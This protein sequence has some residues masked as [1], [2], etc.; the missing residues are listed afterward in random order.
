VDDLPVGPAYGAPTVADL[1]DVTGGASID[2]GIDENSLTCEAGGGGVTVGT[3]GRFTVVFS[4]TASE[5]GT[6]SNPAG[7]CRV[8][9]EGNVSETDENNDCPTDTVNVEVA[10]R[11]IYLPLVVRNAGAP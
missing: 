2:C 5:G 3:A 7:I 4:V 9:P 11:S 6:L 10:S 8:D 1:V